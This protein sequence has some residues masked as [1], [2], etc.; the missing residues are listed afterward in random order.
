MAQ[1]DSDGGTLRDMKQTE[2]EN[3]HQSQEWA[4]GSGRGHTGSPSPG[5]CSLRCPL[6]GH[7]RRG[8][9]EGLV[10]PG[11]DDRLGPEVKL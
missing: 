4:D 10:E 3:T 7:P 1:V 8:K 11:P 9:E 5:L 6:D 2:Y